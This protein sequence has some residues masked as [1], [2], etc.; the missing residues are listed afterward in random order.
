[1]EFFVGMVMA[2]PGTVK[3]YDHIESQVYILTKEEGGKQ[4]P[5]VSYNQLQMFSKTWDCAARVFVPDKEMIMPGEDS[6]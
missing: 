1:M 3:G 4:R 5:I 2:K 6:K